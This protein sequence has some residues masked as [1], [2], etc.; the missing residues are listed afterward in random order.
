MPHY[1]KKDGTITA[2]LT[3]SEKSLVRGM[4]NAQERADG[5]IGALHFDGDLLYEIL[6]LGRELRDKAP[7]IRARSPS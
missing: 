1:H 2:H 4:N 5:N 6:E 7:L 3:E